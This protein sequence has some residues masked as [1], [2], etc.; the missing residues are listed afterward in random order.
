MSLFK[1]AALQLT[2][3]QDP[4][5]N[6]KQIHSGVVSAA[7][8]GASLIALPENFAYMGSED[9]KMGLAETISGQVYSLFP[10]WAREYQIAILAGGF[11]VRAESGKVY[12]RSVLFSAEGEIV[13]EYDKIHLFDVAL[14]ESE[15]YMESRTV[16]A[17]RPVAVT[18]Q[19]ELRDLQDQPFHLNTGLSVCYD[20]RFPELY[21]KLADQGAELILIP[22][23]FT[24]PTGEAHW[25]TLLRARAIENSLFV[26][27]PAQTGIH[28]TSRS[29]YGHSMIIDPWGE[30]LARADTVPGLIT[31]TIE[32]DQI[33]E[34]RRKLPSF[35][36]RRL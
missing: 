27:A 22:A 10:Q 12:N 11:P 25:E 3:L 31:A 4:D 17:G 9:E 14:S 7:E 35:Y 20:L 5:V 33:S 6:I 8:T 2:S 23:A 30:V 21:R 15:T 36:H 34:I 29:T 19:L 32:T 16:E 13:A 28:T 1:V 18:G 24:R 26:I